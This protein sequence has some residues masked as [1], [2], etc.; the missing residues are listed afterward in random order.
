M[1]H[2][3]AGHGPDG[4]LVAANMIHLLPG[5]AGRRPPHIAIA[6][7][8]APVR[9]ASSGTVQELPGHKSAKTAMI[10]THVLNKGCQGVTS[11]VDGP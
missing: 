11:P 1:R 3:S 6:P 8:P 9:P 4:L 5:A 2:P 7:E 10:Y